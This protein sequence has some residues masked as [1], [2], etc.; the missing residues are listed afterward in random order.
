MKGLLSVM[1]NP[2]AACV[3]LGSDAPLYLFVFASD[4]SEKR[5]PLFGLMRQP[6][7]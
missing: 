4:L 6:K 7:A 1:A 5:F 2:R 3:W